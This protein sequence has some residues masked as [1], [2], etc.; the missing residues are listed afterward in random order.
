MSEKFT[1]LVSKTK[2]MTKNK[3]EYSITPSLIPN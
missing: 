3:D 1:D 2:Q